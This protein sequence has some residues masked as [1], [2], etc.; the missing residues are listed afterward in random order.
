M[1]VYH[2]SSFLNSDINIH[3]VQVMSFSDINA[4]GKAYFVG[5][6]TSFDSVAFPTSRGF[7]MTAIE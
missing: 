5:A 6:T 3:A 4:P 2:R 7:I 1:D